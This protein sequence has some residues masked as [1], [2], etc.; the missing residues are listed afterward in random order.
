LTVTNRLRQALLNDISSRVSSVH[1]FGNNLEVVSNGSIMAKLKKIGDNDWV[2]LKVTPRFD[3]LSDKGPQ[4]IKKHFKSIKDAAYA[5]FLA[6]G[7]KKA[8]K[9]LGI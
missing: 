5:V 4:L 6:V 1:G 8:I 9:K 2:I 3:E 7:D